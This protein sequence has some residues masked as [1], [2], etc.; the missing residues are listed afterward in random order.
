M[1]N[2]DIGQLPA[3]LEEVEAVGRFL[4]CSSPLSSC[5]T[6]L[7][8]ASPT[9]SIVNGSAVERSRTTNAVPAGKSADFLQ[10]I[11]QLYSP[12][13]PDQVFKTQETLQK[14]Q[15]S[16]EGWQLASSLM[17]NKD[18]QIRFFAALTFIVKLNTDAWV[19]SVQES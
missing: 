6:A 18:Q 10:L 9:H 15:R 12:G 7:A 1:S 16:P 14:L 11:T 19:L 17:N 2:V 13:R 5:L 4:Y 3:S 8:K